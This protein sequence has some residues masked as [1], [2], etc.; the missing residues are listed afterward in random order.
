[1]FQIH[2]I[3]LYGSRGIYQISE[4]SERNFRGVSKQYYVLNSIKQDGSVICVPVDSKSLQQKMRRILS[5][6]E[7]YAIIKAMP[8][9]DSIWIENESKRK[10]VYR[11]IISRGDRLELIRMIKALYLHKKQQQSNGKKLHA[12]DEQFF[13]EAERLL[14]DEFALVLNIRPDQVLP[15][16]IEQVELEEKSKA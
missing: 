4:V 10:E 2:D 9:E 8:Y 13:K 11:E 14:Y 7:I 3:I 6:E 5:S 16:I 1:M 15:F 12:A